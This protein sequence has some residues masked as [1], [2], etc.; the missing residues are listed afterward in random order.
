MLSGFQWFSM[1]AILLFTFGGGYAP[2]FRTEQARREEGFPLGQAFAAGVFLA[3][4]LTMMLP[5]A[6]NLFNK[7]FPALDYPVAA[8]ITIVAFLV[9]LAL[10]HFIGHLIAGLD[11]ASDHRLSSPVIPIITTAMIAVPSFFLGTALAVSE[12]T[13]AWFILI[14]ILAHKGSAAFALALQMVRSSL[15][16]AQALILFGLFAFATPFGIVVGSDLHVYLGAHTMMVVKAV[17]L[18]LAAGTFLYMGTMHELRHSP[19][20]RDC[21]R[22]KGFGVMLGGLALTALVRFLIGEAHRL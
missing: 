12:T 10:E 20:I 14:A 3:L 15:T 21:A 7:A 11:Q 1:I 17:V 13:A 5:S 8:L 6:F 4:C 18:S 9:L 2:L 19:L 16:R 22:L